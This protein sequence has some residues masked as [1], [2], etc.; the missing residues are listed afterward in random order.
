MHSIQTNTKHRDITMIKKVA[1]ILLLIS[2]RN[3]S[4]YAGEA[5]DASLLS[6]ILDNNKENVITAL[7][8][9][10]NVRALYQG[11]TTT[12]SLA[13]RNG[14]I[15]IATLLLAESI[16]INGN[17]TTLL[18]YAAKYSALNA[19]TELL[20]QGININ[21]QD[22]HGKTAL[23]YAAR[24]GTILTIRLLLQRGAKINAQDNNGATPLHCA[25]ERKSY[26]T[27]SLLAD[28]EDINFRLTNL[29]GQTAHDLATKHG[30]LII[31]N[32]LYKLEAAE[33]CQKTCS[34]S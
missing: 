19:I 13:L 2:S 8:K 7:E 22:M 1:I 30:E 20:N 9:G 25:V 6:A 32:L 34:I 5:E 12:M 16:K 10:A 21:M 27:V 14:N 28:D 26:N 4:I 29:C 23:H 17:D 15:P 18:H 33:S 3:L 24:F 31:A 11:K